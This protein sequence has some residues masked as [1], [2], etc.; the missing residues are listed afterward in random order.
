MTIYQLLLMAGSRVHIRRST[1]RT[2]E[3][4]HQIPEIEEMQESMI[5]SV[6]VLRQE[7]EVDEGSGSGP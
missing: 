6:I 7:S 5:A 1:A 3:K 4:L 2:A